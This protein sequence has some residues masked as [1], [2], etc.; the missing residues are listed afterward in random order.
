M[1][2][3]I[4]TTS[5]RQSPTIE[6]ASQE[7]LI[8][9]I[10]T[11]DLKAQSS[12][13]AIAGK[14]LLVALVV[15][16]LAAATFFSGGA[17][18]GLITGGAVAWKIGLISVASITS[19]ITFIG[20]I[21]YASKDNM[22]VDSGENKKDALNYLGDTFSTALTVFVSGLNFF[23]EYMIWDMIFSKD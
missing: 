4:H 3:A 16:G 12:K 21:Y 13:G 6:L 8:R 11:S 2:E 14:F 18:L 15:A 19:L 20:S 17:A 22:F 7:E 10:D 9:E 1:T 5:A 23:K